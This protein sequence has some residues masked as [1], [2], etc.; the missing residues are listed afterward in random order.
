MVE[1]LVCCKD[2][3][4]RLVTFDGYESKC[5]IKYETRWDS[6]YGE[7]KDRIRCSHANP[8][9]SCQDFKKRKWWKIW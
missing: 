9:G 2:C 8:G 3:H 7:S 4:H 1:Y 6:E 5:G